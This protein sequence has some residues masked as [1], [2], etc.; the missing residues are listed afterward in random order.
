M[1][2]NTAIRDEPEHIRTLLTRLHGESKAQEASLSRADYDKAL[3]HDVM[4]DKFIAL[5][6][7]KAHYIYQLLR[8]TEATTIVEA[9]TSFGVSTIYLALAALANAKAAGGGKTARVVA[10]EHEPTKAAR[11]REHWQLCGDDVVK[12]IDLREGDLRETLKTDLEA[13]DFLLLDSR[14]RT[15]I[16]EPSLHEL[17]LFTHTVWTPMALPTL[18]IVQPKLR[19]GA[20]IIADNTVTAKESYKEFLDYVRA[21]GSGFVGT[22][23]PFEGGLEV[24]V[25]APSQ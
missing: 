1:S 8:A 23:V 5:D 12:A 14:S 9:G 6:E 7:D 13:V 17:W 24:L 4:R 3:I 15:P 11:A 19:H 2:P 21:P 10:T 22:T 25:Y 18:K 16:A 20:L